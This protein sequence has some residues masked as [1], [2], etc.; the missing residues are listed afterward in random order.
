MFKYKIQNA[1][2]NPPCELHTDQTIL[3]PWLIFL[4]QN[5]F[6]SQNVGSSY[7]IVT[8]SLFWTRI[9]FG[10]CILEDMLWTYVHLSEEPHVW[11]PING[12]GTGK[13]FYSQW[14]QITQQSIVAANMKVV[15]R[16]R[17]KYNLT[18]KRANSFTDKK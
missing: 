14:I 16:K 1:T 17:Y 6:P 10:F 2:N 11:T 7:M 18:Q 5:V 4:Q 12:P 15:Y 9:G 13:Q 3:M 8:L